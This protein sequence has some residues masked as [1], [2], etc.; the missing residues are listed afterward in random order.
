M[1]KTEKQETSNGV[2]FF[3]FWFLVFALGRRY[4][5]KYVGIHQNIFEL[6][7]NPYNMLQFLLCL[8]I[9]VRTFPESAPFFG[10]IYTREFACKGTSR[11]K[12][13]QYQIIFR[14]PVL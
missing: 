5:S 7:F 11:T 8:T 3:V 6:S 14:N 4:R 13:V 12:Y 1:K 2:S 10:P 9:S